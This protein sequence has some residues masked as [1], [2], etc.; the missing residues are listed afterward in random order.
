MKQ[1]TFTITTKGC[2]ECLNNIDGHGYPRG[3]K[4]YNRN[5]TLSK[6]IYETIHG[7]LERPLVVRHL[8][9]N[10]LCVNPSHLEKGNQ[11]QNGY[12]ALLDGKFRGEAGSRTKLAKEQVEYIRSSDKTQK[13]LA[14]ELGVSVQAVGHVK[15]G[16]S[17]R[18]R[19]APSRAMETKDAGASPDDL[20]CV[21]VVGRKCFC[22]CHEENVGWPVTDHFCED[23][24]QHV[25]SKEH[26]RGKNCADNE[27][28]KG[29]CAAD[30]DEHTPGDNNCCCVDCCK[31]GELQ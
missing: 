14:S 24:G 29:G 7:R 13:Q 8:C 3:P 19:D 17:W 21:G 31:G 25:V 4:S 1:F 27:P 5:A 26:V 22:K 12:D 28:R 11:M 2:W 10:K 15:T 9:A 18:S 20:C 6:Y 23:C 30:Y 16:Y